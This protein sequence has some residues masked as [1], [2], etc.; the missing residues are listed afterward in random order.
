MATTYQAVETS[1]KDKRSRVSTLL[2]LWTT[3]V[4]LF[5]FWESVRYTGLTAWFA[6]WQFATFE[7]YFPVLT[8]L[9][10][11]ILFSIPVLIYSIYRWRQDKKTVRPEDRNGGKALAASTRMM[12]SLFSISA[13]L[14]LATLIAIIVTA[15]LPE[16][17]GSAQ[18]I[19]VGSSAS[20]SPAEGPATLV[21]NISL[22]TTAGF[23]QDMTLLGRQSYFAP[24]LATVGD[25]KVVRY[26]IEVERLGEKPERFRPIEEGV[27]RRNA[28]PGELIGLYRD[29]KMTVGQPHFV[30]FKSQDGMRW[31]HLAVV[32]QLALLTL[33]CLLFALLQRSRRNRLRKSLA[34][35]ASSG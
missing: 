18:R 5:F 15:T 33:L 4:A 22:K 1:G 9:L 10:F 19:V 12:R 6:D 27:L 8:Y 13:G 3:F 20:L 2:T 26:F 30:L 32:V 17:Q 29:A 25:A 7:R 14:G 34:D 24:V 23:G 11:V 16:A 28:L 31:R 21:G 35:G